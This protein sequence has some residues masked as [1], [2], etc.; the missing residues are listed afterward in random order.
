MES[1]NDPTWTDWAERKLANIITTET[2]AGSNSIDIKCASSIC[3]VTMRFDNAEHSQ[4]AMQ[5][6]PTLVPWQANG[7]FR[8]DPKTNATTVYISREGEQLPRAD[9]PS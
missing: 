4:T 3:R 8:T 6:L 2:V 9:Q 7:Y 5:Q 1:D